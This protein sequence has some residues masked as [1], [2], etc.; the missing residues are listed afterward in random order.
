VGYDNGHIYLYY[1]GY[2]PVKIK[3]LQDKGII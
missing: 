1:F 2:G 3:E